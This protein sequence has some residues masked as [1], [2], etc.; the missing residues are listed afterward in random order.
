MRLGDVPE[1]FPIIHHIR[2]RRLHGTQQHRLRVSRAVRI[3]EN[4]DILYIISICIFTGTRAVRGPVLR[5]GNT[6]GWT[7]KN[8]RTGVASILRPGFAREEMID[9]EQRVLEEG[10]TYRARCTR[11]SGLRGRESTAR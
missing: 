6:G 4:D 8:W 11:A 2:A 1:L 9:K 5:L 7:E 3:E 10:Y